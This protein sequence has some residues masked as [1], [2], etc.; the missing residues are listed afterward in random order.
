M[1]SVES[2]EGRDDV[3]Q[4]ACAGASVNRRGIR[5]QLSLE[6]HTNVLI[7]QIYVGSELVKREQQTG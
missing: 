6:W 4:R 7:K 1:E 3:P 2:V 5:L